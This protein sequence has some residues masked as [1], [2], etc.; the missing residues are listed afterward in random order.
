MNAQH[1]TL[2]A[3]RWGQLSFLEQMAN[4]GSEVERALNWK[5]KNDPQYSMKAFERALELL[6]L[7]L[8]Y[9]QEKF[10]FKEIARTREV[11]VD[12]F[13]GSNEYATSEK[14]LRS[15]FFQFAYAARKHK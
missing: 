8:D 13:M 14:F 3:G 6:D 10:H 4:V 12:F 5:A 2:A 1:K 9:C 11:L 15:Y 7:T